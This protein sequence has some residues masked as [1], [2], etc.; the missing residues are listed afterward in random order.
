MP[1]RLAMIDERLQDDRQVR[2]SELQKR[3][4]QFSLRS[5]FVVTTVWAVLLGVARIFPFFG[6]V[7]VYVVMAMA[8]LIATEAI[9]RTF[10]W[11]S[12]RLSGR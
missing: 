11:I 1:A 2:G 4:R 10:E 8:G 6:V 3:P 5:L 7:L 9:A 12:S